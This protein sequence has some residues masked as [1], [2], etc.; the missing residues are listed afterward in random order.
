[1]PL[2]LYSSQL[3]SVFSSTATR[4]LMTTLPLLPRCPACPTPA[5]PYQVAHHEGPPPVYPPRAHT[6][7]LLYETP[8]VLHDTPLLRRWPRRRRWWRTSYTTSLFPV[9]PLRFCN[10]PRCSP[11]GALRKN[12][13]LSPCNAPT[14]AL[15]ATPQGVPLRHARTA[16][17]PR[18]LPAPLQ[19]QRQS[20]W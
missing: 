4:F 15:L 11:R 19:H 20:H 1:M 16:P 14:R 8:V 7:L 3:P 17:T 6:P 18:P 9:I 2:C 12:L 10:Q 13:S 5:H